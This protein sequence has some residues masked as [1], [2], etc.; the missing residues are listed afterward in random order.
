MFWLN[1]ELLRRRRIDLGWTSERLADEAGLDR[2]T[3]QRLEQ[4]RNRA[5]LGT[6]GA[7]AKA[8]DLKVSSLIVVA[9][10]PVADDDDD[11][12]LAAFRAADH[13]IQTTLS[14]GGDWGVKEVTTVLSLLLTRYGS[15]FS[16]R[17][18]A[19]FCNG[20]WPAGDST[21]LPKG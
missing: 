4:G 6:A 12:V 10:P 11:R 19:G 9:P 17:S 14:D 20:R 2:R 21:S 15:V 1:R 8:L 3:V 16:R 7:L 18:D 5:R 13:A